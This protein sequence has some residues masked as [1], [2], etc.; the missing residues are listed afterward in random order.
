M[1]PDIAIV[2]GLLVLA[3]VLFTTERLPVDVIS[4]GLVAALIGSGI[5]TPAAAFAGFG[6]EVIVILASIMVLAGAIVKAGV[7]AWLGRVSHALA[8]GSK[9]LS[10]LAILGVSTVS[11]AFLSN[12]NTTAI[13]IPAAMETA[14]RA[15]IS[16][17]RILMPLAYASMLG[18]SATLIGT[19]T[20]LAS[21]G[22]IERLNLAPIS[23]FEFLGVGAVIAMV[24]L[25][26]LVF[27]GQ[28]FLRDRRDV[29]PED[30]T[31]PR[32]FFTT[33]C[34]ATGSRAIDMRISEIDFEALDADLLAVVRGD[35]RLS[36]HPA[37]K[38]RAGDELIVRATRD[39]LLKLRK[40][41]D[42]G[43]E[44]ELHF[45]KRMGR[46]M[47]PVVVEAVVMPQSRFVGQS[48]KQIDFFERW[49]GIVLAV[50][51]RHRSAP[52]RLENLL[53]QSGDV[54]L[55]QGQP[56][57]IQNLRGGSDVSI[58]ERV[59][60]TVLTQRQGVIAL[61]AMAAATL[62]GA[63][64]LMPFSLMIL[65][66]VLVVVV[67]GCITMQDAYRFIEWR[68]LVLIAGMS[69]F[70]IAMQDSGTADYLAVHVV[71]LSR[72]FGPVFAMAAFSVLTI[73]L[74][75][76]MSNAAAALTVIPVAVAS[77][78]GL[79]L[80]PRMLAILVTLSASLS[81]ISPLEPACLLVYDPGRYWFFDYVRAGVP[82]TLLSVA[83]LLVLVPL[84]WG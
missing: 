41:P 5:L 1:T 24:G 52:A 16:A 12:T 45:A 30:N 13:L 74:T 67:T 54:L 35:E 23:I 36:P 80:D 81:F 43:L 71:A 40:S 56:Q 83:M 73:I 28:Y 49:H 78:E 14:R 51:R 82:L 31:E 79:G 55:I 32:R 25:V 66:A 29:D 37:R 27:P 15:K 3:M 39:G 72:P 34:L 84:V 2:L 21:S 63:T 20:N 65:V 19:S 38:L 44:P 64:G 48:L 50:Y 42:Y 6:S 57:K 8:G 76:P 17:S 70:G 18:G 4:L 53:L 69:S 61:I 10:I 22:L 11:S 62:L 46:D 59:E 7:M 33:L 47:D 58:L 60:D 75:Q 9:R 77:A 26:W 68:L